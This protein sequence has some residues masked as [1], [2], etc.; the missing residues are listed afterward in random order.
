MVYRLICAV[1]FVTLGLAGC[2]APPLAG[3]PPSGLWQDQA[4]GYQSSLVTET[5]DSVFALDRAMQA[6][7]NT[8]GNQL[9]STRQ[10][11]DLLVARLYDPKGLRL[12][13]ASG[14]TTGAAETWRS[15]SGDCLSLTVMAYAAARALGLNAY[16]QEVQVPLT[17]DRRDGVDFIGGHVN[18]LVRHAYDVPLN[19]RTMNVE[20]FVVDFEPQMG[21]NR[22]GQRLTEDDIMARYYNNRAAQYLIA[23]D[24]ARAYAYYRAAIAVGPGYAPAFAN[25]AQLY[26]RKGLLAGAEQLLTHAIALGGPTYSALRNMQMLLTTQGR[27]AEAQ[28]YAQLLVKQ[29][30]ESPYYWMGLGMA[31]MRDSDYRAAIRTLERAAA[32]ATGFEEIHYQLALAYWRDGQQQAAREQLAVL[33][34]INHHAP[35]VGTLSKKFSAPPPTSRPGG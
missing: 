2:A 32:L 28:H 14:R 5:R 25:L 4:F 1:I 34:G 26:V 35:G 27:N 7:L 29:Q 12:S 20:N 8:P 24:D 17:F 13:Y 18:L 31:A 16:M 6:S 3:A 30:N 9:Q 33:D 19:D 11:L 22:F 15:Q 10:R 23:K 21:A